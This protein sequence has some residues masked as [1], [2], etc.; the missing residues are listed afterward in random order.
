MTRS[1]RHKPGA[2]RKSGA[3]KPGRKIG[4][5]AA[6]KKRQS[7]A[8]KQS[9]AAGNNMKA[10]RTKVAALEEELAAAKAV[11]KAALAKTCS[12][13]SAMKGKLQRLEASNKWLQQALKDS[14]KEMRDER[15]L[16]LRIEACT[17][18]PF[19]GFIR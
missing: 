10:L 3:H 5:S 16:R 13:C 9:R 2:A 14:E 17:P 4:R 15:N 19:A 11:A 8:K 18:S 7:E 6:Y 12:D 1:G